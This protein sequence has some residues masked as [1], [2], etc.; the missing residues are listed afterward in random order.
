VCSALTIRPCIRDSRTHWVRIN[1]LLH[2]KK[3]YGQSNCS[4]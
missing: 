4:V 3:C 2:K 1:N